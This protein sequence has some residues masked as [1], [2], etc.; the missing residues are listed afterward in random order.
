MSLNR[1]IEAKVSRVIKAP[2]SEVWKALVDPEK[3]SRYLFGTKVQSS[4]EVG[5]EI[6]FSGEYNGQSYFDK[7]IILEFIPDKELSY[8]YWSS[9]S[10]I[11]DEPDNYSLV[12]FILE[13]EPEGCKLTVIQQGFKDKDSGKHSETAWSQIL[14][15]LSEVVEQG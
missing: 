3:V 5:T 12:R 13:Q 7:G 2:V 15:T 4:W 6:C 10:G 9:F 11:S 1:N 14:S 8:T